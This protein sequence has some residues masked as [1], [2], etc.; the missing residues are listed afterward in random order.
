MVSLEASPVSV[1]ARTSLRTRLRILF[2]SKLAKVGWGILLGVA[3]FII[4]GTFLVH[5]SPYAV[6]GPLFAKPTLAHP[7][8]TDYLGRDILSQVIFGAYPTLATSILAAAVSTILG[9]IGGI[10][11]GYYRREGAVVGGLA[12]SM[13]AIPH[14][15]LMIIVATTFLMQMESYYGIALSI[16]FIVVAWA[17]VAR[18]IRY[19]TISVKKLAFVEADRLSGMSNTSLIWKVIALETGTIGIAY[20]IINLGFAI[21]TI[22]S[23]QF[24]GVGNALLVS[25]G[26]ILYW[27]QEYAF[28]SGSWWWI[29]APG[30]VISLTT[31]GFALVGY[32]LEEIVNPRL[33][34]R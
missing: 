6:T 13:M 34:K 19:Q 32:S 10:Y 21:V 20:F 15:P 14:I 9:F 7:F 24:L 16:P 17:P 12:D 1:E 23:L 5:Y 28:V 22:S 18:A 33:K 8:G 2:E 26:S 3:V 29:I 25:W 4:A 27:A 11:A 31:M 30:I